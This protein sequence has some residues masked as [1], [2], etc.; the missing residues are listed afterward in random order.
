MARIA[1]P[2][3]FAGTGPVTEELAELWQ[4]HRRW[5]AVVL[6]AHRPHG[7]ELD[8][9]LQEV[10]L[11]LVRRYGDLRDRS[12][13]RP[14][15]RAIAINQAREAR[16]RQ[17]GRPRA[18]EQDGFERM[19]DTDRSLERLE[20][21]EQAR[22]VLRQALEL[23]EELREPLL[24]RSVRGLTQK[25][26]AATLELN[27]TTVESRIARARRLLR[28]RTTQ[29]AGPVPARTIGGNRHAGS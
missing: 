5:V 18:M 29:P 11:T 16:R 14:W 1:R 13:I 7:S 8:D 24:L 15:L 4:E 19:V 27:E 3:P 23:P 28:D 17:L 26:I 10:A 25:Q 12:R 21:Q 22:L 9:L 20:L 2:G 6:L